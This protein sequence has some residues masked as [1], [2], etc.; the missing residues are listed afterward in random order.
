MPEHNACNQK[1]CGKQFHNNSVQWDLRVR[2]SY[3]GL[4]INRIGASVQKTPVAK[5]V[6]CN[7]DPP[8]WE[9]RASWKRPMKNGEHSPG[10]WDDR[11]NGFSL[12]RPEGKRILL[13]GLQ[14]FLVVGVGRLQTK[15]TRKQRKT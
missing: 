5:T 15:H 1:R 8:V 10:R 3:R 13:F 7:S 12:Q 11:V 4:R 9:D 14:W 6:E 2:H